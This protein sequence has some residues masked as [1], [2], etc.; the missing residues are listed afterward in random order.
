MKDY[1]AAGKSRRLPADVDEAGLLS[2]L[3]DLITAARRRVASVA[4]AIPSLLCWHVGRRFLR[5]N[6]HEV[7]AAYGK[8]IA[9]LSQQLT[10]DFGDGFSSAS[11]RQGAPRNGKRQTRGMEMVSEFS[12]RW[13]PRKPPGQVPELR[14]K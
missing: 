7:R 13:C 5:E 6:L 8:R 11:P 12:K 4:N 10:A 14:T 1:E 2:D 9:T 3:R